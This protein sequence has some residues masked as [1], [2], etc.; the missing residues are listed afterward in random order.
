[1]AGSAPGPGMAYADQSI[2]REN[3]IMADTVSQEAR[4]RFLRLAT[5]G[6]ASA[7][8]SGML[9]M[10]RAHAQEKVDPK[11]ELAQQLGYTTDASTVDASQWPTYE[12]G[13]VCANCQLF[14]GEQGQEWGPCDLFG[15][16]LVPAQ[17]W[18]S[19]WTKRE[20]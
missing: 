2:N 14:H 6:I 7:P 13:Q 5:A 17:G 10:G 19:G 20:S 12:K 8:F 1:M 16:Q 3:R 11:S 15:G 4:R 9:A 18:C